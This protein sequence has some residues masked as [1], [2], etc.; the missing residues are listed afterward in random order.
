MQPNTLEVLKARYFLKDSNGQ[1]IEDWEGMCNRTASRAAYGLTLQPLEHWTQ[2]QVDD[3]S[4]KFSAMQIVR[5]FLANSPVYF[6]MGTKHEMGSACF[7][8]PVGDS[9]RDIYGAVRN[10]AM[11]E[12]MG[13]GI[14]MAFDS[15]RPRDTLTSMGTRASGALSFMTAFDTM[16]ETIK[17][18][19]KRRGAM[20]AAMDVTHPEVLEFIDCKEKTPTERV[21]FLVSKYG[22]TSEQAE[23][24]LADLNWRAPFSNFNITVKLNDRFMNDLGLDHNEWYPLVNPN[25]TD[26]NGP[27]LDPRNSIAHY[28]GAG[29]ALN[30]H[31]KDVMDRIIEKAWASGEPGI[32]FID[33]INRD[34]PV[35]NLGRIINPNPC[36]EYWQI[37]F[38]SCNL[39]SI[40]LSKFYSNK[41][42]ENGIDWERLQEVTT[43]A[44]QF[45][46]GILTIN[47]FP[48]DEIKDVTE[49]TRPIG[50]GVMGYADLLLK[51]GV[52]YGSDAAIETAQ[53]TML[54]IDYHAW[55]E[56]IRQAQIKGPFTHFDKNSEYFLTKF[57]R[58][59]KAFKEKFGG[60]VWN[61]YSY[62]SL[63][64]ECAKYGVRNC[65]VTTVA[66][67][68]TISLMAECSSGIEP[69][70]AYEL[71]RQDT[72]STREY[73]HWFKKEWEDTALGPLANHELP[74]YAVEAHDVTPE[75]HIRTQ[76]AFQMYCD[77]AV[78]KT[79]NLPKEATKDDVR[80][81]YM[82]A[83]NTG[84]KSITVYR[85]GCREG[86]LLH[87]DRKT[88]PVAVVKSKVI[89]IKPPA[90]TNGNY[91]HR[92]EFLPG[93]TWKVKAPGGTVYVTVSWNPEENRIVEVFVRENSG[94]EAW[95]L[96]GRLLSVLFRSGMSTKQVMKQLLRTRGQSTIVLD[97]QILTSV[98][99]AIA[100]IL[101]MA[102]K[103]FSS[104]TLP[105]VETP[106]G[107]D[108]EEIVIEQVDI[109]ESKQAVRDRTK[110]LENLCPDCGGKTLYKTEGCTKCIRATC[111]FNRCGG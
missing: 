12:K 57:Q 4:H 99:Q 71:K 73:T 11:I 43:L 27:L 40:N 81:A 31:A 25:G 72:I 66:P 83:W 1:T 109:D 13:G 51:Q 79:I 107:P 41:F 39:G 75:E 102:E 89:E 63:E 93:G 59:D 55:R 3:L 18:G 91:M 80:K 111:G 61:K 15:L 97:G 2:T 68:G 10:G 86:V 8:L 88:E 37:P 74:D 16:T 54:W 90:D 38:S 19:G 35:P 26:Y 46:E 49:H 52:R 78:S 85:D 84:C 30:Y 7:I 22:L 50:L 98:A 24:V 65:Q 96:A 17:Q 62:D 33:R 34:N 5:E 108:E 101:E 106:G 56:S 92:P 44:V 103:H 48:I 105:M 14:G 76:A 69:I 70:F 21:D 42:Q 53:D 110:F 104:P 87:S 36:G 77:N 95:E 82:L 67:T 64:R 45:L 32:G 94:N 58:L 9:I 29:N 23:Q 60:Y 100:V 6:N 47:K 20:M 28:R